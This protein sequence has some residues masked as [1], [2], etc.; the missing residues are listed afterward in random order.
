MT[1]VFVVVVTAAVMLVSL[2]RA[3]FLIAALLR[4]RPFST[5][6]TLPAVT[7]LVPARNE[8][9]VASRLLGAL[10]RL[11]Y[12]ADRISFIFMCDGCS[13]G[14]AL[15]FRSWADQHSNAHVRELAVHGGKAAAL[16]AGLL[17]A[18]G[19]ILVVVDADLAPRPD[20]LLELTRPFADDRVGAAAAFLRPRNAD[21]NLL[22]RYAA[23]TSWVHQLVTSAGI[24]RLGF[25]P[26]TLGAAAYR[27]TALE[28]I[29]GFPL[30]PI[31]VDIAASTRIIHRGWRTRF[32]ATAVADNTV[33][34]NARHFWR[35]HIRWGRGVW[36]APRGDR[37]PSGSSWLQRLETVAATIGYGDRLI[38]AAAAGGTVAGA[39]PFW[40]PMLYLAVPGIEIIAALGRAGVGWRMPRFLFA[41]IVFFPVDLG[42]SVAAVLAHLARRPYRW[43]NPRWLPAGDKTG[44]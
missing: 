28:S 8:R 41:G 29:D 36:G 23:I 9:A 34:S 13:D 22:T 37:S 27:R 16:N 12:P 40:V 44:R 19:T 24:D 14:S 4:P 11:E 26:P 1:S 18:T 2:R 21:D 5:T 3:I 30:V 33:V 20:F 6:A 38:F 17:L 43:H 10:S 42:A 32:V 25:N 35:Q 7:V 31:G 39:L 15:V